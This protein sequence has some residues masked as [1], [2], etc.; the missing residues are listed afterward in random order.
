MTSPNRFA[1]RKDSNHKPIVAELRKLGFYVWELGLP[2]D[3]I[4]TRANV[5]HLVELKDGQKAKYTDLQL[6]Y[7]RE[8]GGPVVTLRSVEDAIQWASVV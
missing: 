5:H 7:M 4:C 8:C 1:M 3:L 6:K 2:V